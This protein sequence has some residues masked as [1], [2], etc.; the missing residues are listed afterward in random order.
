MTGE[1]TRQGAGRPIGFDREAVL[2]IAMDFLWDGG[3][4]ATPIGDMIAAMGLSRSSFYAAF[5]SKRGVLLE[6]IEHYSR[7]CVDFLVDIRESEAGPR[8]KLRDMIHGLAMVGDDRGCF[9]ANCITERGRHDPEVQ[10][11]AAAHNAAVERIVVDVLP[12]DATGE[13]SAR[14]R[15]LISAAYGATL[16]KTAGT[17][18]TAIREML[19]A[20]IDRI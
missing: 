3:F 1:R 5:G 19:D 10:R 17:D 18:R 9:M 6:A 14:A 2:A 4:E 20:V 15:A 16:M 11:L 7:R 8:A 13:R 12:P